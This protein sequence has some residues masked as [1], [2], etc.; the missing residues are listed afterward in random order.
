MGY[1]RV[2]DEATDIAIQLKD[3]DH[4]VSILKGDDGKIAW[5]VLID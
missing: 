3:D 1:E 4:S 2:I 5:L